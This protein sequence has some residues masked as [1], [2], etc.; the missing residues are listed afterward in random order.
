MC[1]FFGGGGLIK[2]IN[3]HPFLIQLSSSRSFTSV[4]HLILVLQAEQMNETLSDKMGD[5]K[6][7]ASFFGSQQ[8]AA[9]SSQKALRVQHGQAADANVDL[10]FNL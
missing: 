8:V 3:L 1:D 5:F 7:A 9:W 6:K 2:H 10:H 4:I